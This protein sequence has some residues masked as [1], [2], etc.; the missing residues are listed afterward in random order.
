MS[1]SLSL[2]T[3]TIIAPSDDSVFGLQEEAR[4]AQLKIC[5]HLYAIV[6]F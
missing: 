6:S 1:L 5:N 2:L 3:R 4:K